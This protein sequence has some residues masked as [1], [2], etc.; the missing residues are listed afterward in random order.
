MS[1]VTPPPPTTPA[2]WY[3]D[4]QGRMRWW[5]GQQW[6]DAY[7][8]LVVQAPRTPMNAVSVT[9]FVLS[10]SA[11]VFGVTGYFGAALGVLG[12]MISIGGY[13]SKPLRGRGF[14]VAGI[15]VGATAIVIGVLSIIRNLS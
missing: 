5:D 10:L 1:N 11:F 3:N 8:P 9:G 7:A 6:T 2:G 14:A 12:L 13:A 4:D 15:I